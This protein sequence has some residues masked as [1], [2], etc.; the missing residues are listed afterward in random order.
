VLYRLDFLHAAERPR[1]RERLI[2]AD[3]WVR[4]PLPHNP[5]FL[6]QQSVR[7]RTYDVK[8]DRGSNASTH[9]ATA[10][11]TKQQQLAAV[12]GCSASDVK[13]TDH[14]ARRLVPGRDY[15]RWRKQHNLAALAREIVG[16]IR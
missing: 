9:K 3:R 15:L 11:R 2:L 6:P 13:E 8:N 1:V 5:G 7:P 16:S 14:V 12:D 10:R 4:L